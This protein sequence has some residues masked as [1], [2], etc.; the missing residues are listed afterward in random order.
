M[1]ADKNNVNYDEMWS[2]ADEIHTYLGNRPKMFP[3]F[4]GDH[5]VIPN[6]ERINNDTLNTIKRFNTK[7]TKH[8][9]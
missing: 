7:Y 6:L 8:L 5:Y 2:Y 4:I 1:I 9:S 3:G